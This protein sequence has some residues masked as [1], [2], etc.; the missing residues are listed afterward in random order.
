MDYLTQSMFWWHLG[1]AMVLALGINFACYKLTLQ[2][3][4]PI[5]F[6]GTI[7]VGYLYEL[8]QG[9]QYDTGTDLMAD[10]A[11]AGVMILL[12]IIWNKYE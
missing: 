12:I 9:R 8:Y 10:I 7:L 4:L 5:A 3:R 1:L 2:V 6:F 11:G